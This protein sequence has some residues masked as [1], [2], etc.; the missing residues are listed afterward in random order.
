MKKADH[1]Q[2]S[3]LR[4]RIEQ[5]YKD[6]KAETMQLDN[7]S[8]F[9]LAAAISAVNDVYFYMTTHDW[10]DYNEANYLLESENP[11]KLLAE[12]WE[13]YMEDTG[14]DFGEMLSRLASKWDEDYMTGMV[15]EEL[16]DKYGED[17]SLDMDDY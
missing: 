17:T 11:L 7:K 1:E 4:E 13:A 16:R 8:I 10:A 15:A 12:E 3:L 14:E 5:N 2:T 6:F 9:E